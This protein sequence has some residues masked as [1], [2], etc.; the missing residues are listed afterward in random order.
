MEKRM[1]KA[2][3]KTYR[4]ISYDFG[5]DVVSRPFSFD[6]EMDEEYYEFLAK[7]LIKHY[8]GE[9]SKKN[10]IMVLSM[11][12]DDCIS[13]EW[14]FDAVEYILKEYYEEEA[15]DVFGGYYEC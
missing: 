11:I 14:A 10:I 9:L 7:S 4:T 3:T 2:D 1:K 12:K 8:D 15:R 5:N 6:V 13:E